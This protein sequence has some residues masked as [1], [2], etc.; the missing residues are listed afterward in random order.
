M[1]NVII[2]EDHDFIAQFYKNEI[3]E[4]ENINRIDITNSLINAYKLLVEEEKIYDLAILDLGLPH[5]VEKN[6]YSGEDLAKIIRKR[7]PFTKIVFI[8]GLC[9]SMQL[10][11]IF[12]NINPEGF[13]EK[14]DV[15]NEDFANMIRNILN[16]ETFI[17]EFIKKLKIELLENENYFDFYNIQ[18]I[19][20][21]SQG[22]KTKDIPNHIPLTLSAVHK[23]KQK[24]KKTLNIESGNDM[25]II[26][27]AQ[28]RKIK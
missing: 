11:S 8:S 7:T 16:G 6:L 15:K 21:I 19:K 24:I 5:Y 22:I 28:K 4:I 26:I 10:I 1:K 14:C 3:S 23:R 20:L 2:V 18:I 25:D 9:N 12:Q 13:L 17:G 27:E